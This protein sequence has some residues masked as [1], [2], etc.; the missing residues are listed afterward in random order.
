MEMGAG[1]EMR[2][3]TEIGVKWRLKWGRGQIRAGV[4]M[5]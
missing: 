4:E 1:V 3:E 5:G 2:L